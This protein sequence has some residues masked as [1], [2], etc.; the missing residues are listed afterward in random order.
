[1]LL[2]RRTTAYEISS[3][4]KSQGHS[5]GSIHGNMDSAER[6][7]AIDEFRQGNFKVL[8]T[9]NLIARGIDI[10]QVSLVVNYD[11]PLNQY[12]NPNPEVYL[13][14]IGRTGRYGRIGISVI[15]VHDNQTYQDMKYLEYHFKINIERVPTEDWEE[16]ERIFKKVVL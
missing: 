13:H 15:F 11:M 7:K 4:M 3:R 16:V 12:G 5:V 2:Q 9:T 14:R 8:I 6:D 10:S 1:V